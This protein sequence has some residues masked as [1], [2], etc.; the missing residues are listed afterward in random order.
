MTCIDCGPARDPSVLPRSKWSSHPHYPDQLLL[1]HSHDGFRRVSKDL[2]EKARE[3]SGAWRSAAAARFRMWHASMGNHEANEEG[4]LYPFL[5][6]R[7]GTTMARLAQDHHDLHELRDVVT[8]ALA[9]DGDTYSDDAVLSALEQYDAAL[10][11][12]LEREEETVI[13]LLL[14]LSPEEF[15]RYYDSSIKQLLAAM[16]AC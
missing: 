14:E 8:R 11:D 12:H 1:L 13:P 10:R 16:P 7:Y 2:V 6:R 3:H 15:D 5:A 4:K 9:D